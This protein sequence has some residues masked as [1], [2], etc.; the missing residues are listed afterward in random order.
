MKKVVLDNVYTNREGRKFIVYKDEYGK[1]H[2]ESYARYLMEEYLGYELPPDKDVHHKD[3][4]KTNDTLNN[5]EIIDSKQHKKTHA[6]KY[7]D[8]FEVCAECGKVFLVTSKQNSQKQRN[9]NRGHGK[10]NEYFCSRKCSG[11]HNQ[12]IQMEHQEEK[13]PE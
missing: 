1:Y 2:S 8:T 5:L 6:L 4:D 3:G 7:K 9:A 11:K 13:S 10:T 12:R